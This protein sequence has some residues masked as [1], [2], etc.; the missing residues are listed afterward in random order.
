MLSSDNEVFLM[1]PCGFR[2][3]RT[4]SVYTA[5]FETEEFCLLSVL[6]GKSI[7]PTAL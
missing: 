6:V 3:T 7:M 5:N 1:S 4:F 2:A